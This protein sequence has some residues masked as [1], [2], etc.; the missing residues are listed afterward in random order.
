M[1]NEIKQAPTWIEEFRSAEEKYFSY[2]DE[3]FKSIGN[4]SETIKY[5]DANLMDLQ[6]RLTVVLDATDKLKNFERLVE[7][8]SRNKEA[9]KYV[10]IIRDNS[11]TLKKIGDGLKSHFAVLLHSVTPKSIDSK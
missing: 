5:I 11:I 9:I 10:N 7:G 1:T 3:A 4:A 6:G 8:E 2:I